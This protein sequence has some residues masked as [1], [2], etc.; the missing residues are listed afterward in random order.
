MFMTR[1]TPTT[2]APANPVPTLTPEALQALL[3]EVAASREE[4][5]RQ[6]LELDA[7]KANAAK[8][9][10]NGQSVS[11]KNEL[12]TIRAF[13]KAGY[14]VVVPHKDV[15]TFNRFLAEGLRPK[16]GSKSLKVSGL[17]LFHISQCRPLSAE[18]LKALKAAKDQPAAPR[19]G[20]AATV[21]ELHPQ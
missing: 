6:K 5:V 18:E 12:A 15:K 4:L 19:K 20:K 16:E 17:R 1:K 7:L 11:A 2:E 21:T 14:G 3:A 13:K 8:P 9:A 10:A